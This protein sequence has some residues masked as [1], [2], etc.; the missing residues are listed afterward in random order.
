MRDERSLPRKAV[1]PMS[2]QSVHVLGSVETVAQLP[3]VGGVGDGYLVLADG[4]IYVWNGASWSN[5]QGGGGGSGAIGP[6]GPQGDP[7]PTG[8]A[9]IDGLQGELGPTGAQGPLGPVGPAGASVR[10]VGSV[11]TPADLPASAAANGDAYICDSDGDL[12][13]WDGATWLNVGQ[14]VG[15]QGVEGS[16]GVQGPQGVDGPQGAIGPAGI[17]GAT[18]PTGPVA[19]DGPQG[20]TGPTGPVVA[21]VT[22]V[23]ITAN[24]T[25]TADH[26]GKVLISSGSSAVILTVPAT[27]PAGFSCVFVQGGAGSLTIAGGSVSAR[28]GMKLA[29]QWA[30]ATLI[31]LA[32]GYVL[33]GDTT[34]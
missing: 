32:S 33:S 19:L 15:P 7:G 34:V 26:L 25:L 23:S 2:T 1:R 16:Q 28:T 21:A 30:A 24:T 20:F 10:I 27:L 31:P 8:P 6:A 18:G 29:G 9:G 17:D 5:A 22:S 11:P 12:Y 14:I 4:A 13:V 3:P